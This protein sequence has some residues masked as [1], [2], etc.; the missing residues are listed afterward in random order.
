MFPRPHKLIW[1]PFLSYLF[2]PIYLQV[3]RLEALSRS[4]IYAQ[5]S[6]SIGG[7]M[8]LR[9]FGA[10]VRSLMKSVN[11]NIK[12]VLHASILSAD[13][14][15]SASYL[16]HITLYYSL[17]RSLS[18]PYIPL[19]SVNLFNPPYRNGLMRIFDLNW[20][21]TL[22]GSSPSFARAGG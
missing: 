15:V 4:P 8:T 22:K 17:Y 9:V 10:A 19:L 13:P 20:I 11:F 6:E 2:K 7:L 16:T 18:L 1:N 12:S 3:K 14:Y 5:L 21:R